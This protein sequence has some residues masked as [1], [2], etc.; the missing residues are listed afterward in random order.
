MKRG[1]LKRLQDRLHRQ[2]Q[3]IATRRPMLV[4]NHQLQLDRQDVDNVKR[5]LRRD[6]LKQAHGARMPIRPP[7]G[8]GQIGRLARCVGFDLAALAG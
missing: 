1:W 7:V 6:A 3:R 8:V 5:P 2:N 4:D